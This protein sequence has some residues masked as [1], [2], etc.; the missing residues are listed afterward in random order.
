MPAPQK[1]NSTSNSMDNL[2][3]TI[4]KGAIIPNW[5]L[6]RLK[7]EELYKLCEARNLVVEPTGKRGKGRVVKRDYIA[8][9][10]KYCGDVRGGT[11][12]V[13]STTGPSSADRLSVDTEM[14]FDADILGQ[15]AR[16]EPVQVVGIAQVA[17]DWL[18]DMNLIQLNHRTKSYRSKRV[19]IRV[20][21]HP[22]DWAS[23]AETERAL[24]V[25][26]GLDLHELE[27]YLGYQVQI[28]A[29]RTYRPFFE[30]VP[31]YIDADDLVELLHDDYIR[32]VAKK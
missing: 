12:S 23:I 22:K 24:E 15:N 19:K 27:G 6:Q 25:R 32:V 2:E 30:Y 1:K 9:I 18:D 28:I 7:T 20:F 4:D 21:E 11:Q 3:L 8:A 13:G 10:K 31:G 29:P 14:A 5:I 26:G 16:P 17:R